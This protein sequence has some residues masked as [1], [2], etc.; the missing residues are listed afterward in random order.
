M[1]RFRGCRAATLV[2]VLILVFVGAVLV[3]QWPVE[4]QTLTIDDDA[5]AS[6]YASTLSQVSE[7]HEKVR[8]RILDEAGYD[9]EL[10]ARAML[11]PTRFPKG[12]YTL[13]PSSDEYV[14]RLRWQLRVA[15]A[16]SPYLRELR[17]TVDKVATH[18]HPLIAQFPF[19]LIS[20]DK[21]AGSGI[22][23]LFRMWAALLPLPLDESLADYLPEAEWA[24]PA[25]EG[26][27]WKID[28][29]DDHRINAQMSRWIGESSI[30]YGHGVW[31]TKWK[32]MSYTLR[33]DIYR[34]ACPL[35]LI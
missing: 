2:K 5:L 22:P 26:A 6:L 17:A 27:H 16:N 23:D 24:T 4:R 7:E 10:A 8:T 19:N 1:P 34:Y 12:N 31:P 11:A 28:V 3:H 35:D 25:R 21:L 32:K 33:A 20:T 14:T 9:P 18:Q 15:M 13:S 30:M 29:A